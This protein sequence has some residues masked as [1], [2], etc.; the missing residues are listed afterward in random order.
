MQLGLNSLIDP[1]LWPLA[2]E[3]R[4]FYARRPAGR[5]P[6]DWTEL[7]ECRARTPTPLPS[8]PPATEELI[9]ADRDVPVRFHLPENRQPSGVLIDI[10]GGGFFMGSAAMRDASNRWLADLLG[11]VVASVDYRLAPEHPWPC[12]PDDCE[13]AALWLT[14]HAPQR[15]GTDHM[16]ITGFSAGATLA[17]VTLLRLKERGI[18]P[19]NGAVL[20]FGTYDLAARTPAGRLISDEYFLSAYAGM[21]DD[22]T[23]PDISPIYAELSGLPPIMIVVGAKDILLDDNMAMAARLSAAGVSV[24][25]C[26]YPESPHGFTNHDTSMAQTARHHM[27]SWIQ[28]C[29]IPAAQARGAKSAK[30][31]DK[32]I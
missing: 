17:A 2:A 1:C 29:L 25:L 15:F 16:A 12:A 30:Y 26:V 4:E 22:R 13:S 20:Q 6:R 27:H 28:S 18:D 9:G 11:V 8:C 31:Q 21:A 19:F 7:Q 5:G 23:H 3:S 10:H 32:K 14:E 24:D